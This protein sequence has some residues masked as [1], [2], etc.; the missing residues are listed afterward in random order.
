MKRLHFT[1]QE[2]KKW[3]VPVLILYNITHYIK[4]WE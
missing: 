2:V 3:P 1:V 4:Q